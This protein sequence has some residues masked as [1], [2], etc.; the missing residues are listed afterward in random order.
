MDYGEIFTSNVRMKENFIVSQV[1]LFQ[2]CRLK[3]Y[4]I[5]FSQPRPAATSMADTVLS[6]TEKDPRKLVLWEHDSTRLVLFCASI[7]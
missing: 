4:L 7:I 5:S 3:V 1:W 6:N 2:Y